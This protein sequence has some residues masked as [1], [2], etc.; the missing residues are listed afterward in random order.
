[1]R[2][3]EVLVVN[4]GGSSRTQSPAPTS[5]SLA[6]RASPPLLARRAS[7]CSRCPGLSVRGNP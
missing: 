2:V 1:M 3:G 7:S 4:E 5:S 6:R